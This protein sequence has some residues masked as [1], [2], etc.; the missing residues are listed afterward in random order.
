ML[1]WLFK[2]PKTRLNHT[3]RLLITC[4]NKQRWGLAQLLLYRI[5][6]Q[7]GIFLPLKQMVPLSTEFPH[8]A[9]IVIGDGVRLGERVKIY[10]GVTLGGA[11]RG[12]WQAGNYP[13]IG[14]DV[15]LFAG[16][17]VIGKVTIGNSCI[18]GANAVVLT[19][20]PDGHTAVGAPARILA[21]KS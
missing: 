16:A 7:H 1:N 17:V 6:N 19:D 8:P 3:R 13:V 2:S 9:S 12:D 10:Q 20:V 18:I 11:R 14:S 21:P 5:Q 15:I 4:Q